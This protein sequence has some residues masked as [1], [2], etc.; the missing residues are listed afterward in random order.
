MSRLWKTPA[1]LAAIV[2]LFSAGC[3]QSVELAVTVDDL[4]SHAALAPGMSNPELARKMTAVLNRQQVPEVYGFVNAGP[5]DGTPLQDE[6]LRIWTAAGHPLGNHTYRHLNS[7]HIP[8]KEFVQGVELNE[9]ALRRWTPGEKWKVFR[10]PFLVEGADDA[11]W[12]AIHGYL[13][14]RGYQVAPVTVDSQGWAYN[15]AYVRCLQK[16]REE[17]VR[18]L[19]GQYLKSSLEALRDAAE[20]AQSLYQGPIRQVLLLHFS[21]FETDVLDEL[22]TEYRDRGVKFIPL[23]EALKDPANQATQR[24]PKS[25]RGSRIML[26]SRYPQEKLE[27]LCR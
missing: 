1:T 22:L 24:Q 18:W 9:P 14:G 2:L 3:R 12:D 27:Q 21:Q 7:A 20:A 13:R 26:Q 25:G 15:D 4:P 8:L 19:K 5:H 11:H 17:D 6:V 23:S 10:F 16:N